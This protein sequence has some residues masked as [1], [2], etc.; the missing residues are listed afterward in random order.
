M[1]RPHSTPQLGGVSSGSRRLAR[2]VP[3]PLCYNA[4]MTPKLTEEQRQAISA[5]PGG[6]ARVEDEET[7]K[8]YLI[9]E[10]SRASELYE[11]WL[12]HELQKGFDAADRGEVAEW[13]LDEFLAEAH[14]RH[15]E[16]TTG[17][18]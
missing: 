5:E 16:R 13:S 11:Q 1:L 18:Q 4:G 14:R 6:F 12:R 17:T 2:P 15:R 10:E 8:V 9:I 3:G 7:H